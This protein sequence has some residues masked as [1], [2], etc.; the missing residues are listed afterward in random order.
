MG[1]QS[2]PPYNDLCFHLANEC[3]I[4][5]IDIGVGKDTSE[6]VDVAVD[7]STEKTKDSYNFEI[8]SIEETNRGDK[9]VKEICMAIDTI[10]EKCD[11]KCAGYDKCA[12]EINQTDIL[13]RNEDSKDPEARAVKCK[14]IKY[15]LDWTTVVR[16]KLVKLK[17]GVGET[18]ETIFQD[19]KDLV[20]HGEEEKKELKLMKSVVKSF[21]IIVKMFPMKSRVSMNI[22]LMKKLINMLF[23]RKKLA[24][25]MNC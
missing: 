12:E 9:N 19:L 18:A 14:L 11:G 23:Q 10:D 15:L 8:E 22:T 24:M 3:D 5:G 2:C 17:K 6:E 16:N 4:L 13:N 1:I 7:S 20:N 21:M 25:K